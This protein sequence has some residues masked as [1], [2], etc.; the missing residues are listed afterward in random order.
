MVEIKSVPF[1]ID[2]P[3]AGYLF[4]AKNPKAQILLQHGYGEYTTRYVT[5]YSKL[6]PKLVERGFDVYGIDLEGH[7]NTAGERGLI[8]V[9]QAVEHHLLA[10]AAMPTT[11]PTFLFGHSLGGLVT[12]GSITRDQSNITA[13]IISSSAMQTPSKL[14]ERSLTK[15]M[16]AIAPSGPLPLPRP[17]IEALTRDAE[18][19]KVIEADSEMFKGKAKNKVA[20]TTLAVSDGVWAD[21][22]NWLVPTL[23]IHG[24][25]DTSTNFENSVSLHKAIGS[26]DKT[27]KVYEGGFHELLNDTIAA[28]VEKDLFAWLDA[29][30][31]KSK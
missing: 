4:K 27:L 31:P 20:K 9:Q 11:L 26:K 13:A 19:L 6:I 24:D 7:G 23:F 21:A 15:V 16:T 12:A 5:Q 8:D 22:S 14:W 2:A 17:G 30:T 18:L 28:K 25:Q 3:V 29:R 1:I 10:R